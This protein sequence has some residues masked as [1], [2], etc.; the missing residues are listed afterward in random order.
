MCNCT[1]ACDKSPICQGCVTASATI[2][3]RQCHPKPQPK[4]HCI[5]WARCGMFS[6]RY[7]YMHSAKASNSLVCAEGSILSF[8]F[9]VDLDSQHASHSDIP[10]LPLYVLLSFVSSP[11]LLLLSLLLLD[12]GLYGCCCC[13]WSVPCC[14][15]SAKLAEANPEPSVHGV[16]IR[17]D[18]RRRSCRTAQH[19]ADLREAT[20]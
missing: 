11:L 19:T 8:L 5:D 3:P 10:F 7:S 12:S 4:A 6:C 16:H 18:E 20:R 13:H 15:C 9:H 17:F 1:R 2:N 14:P